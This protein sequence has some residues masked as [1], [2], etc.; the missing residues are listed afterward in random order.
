MDFNV[1]VSASGVRCGLPSM[2]IA[3]QHGSKA[4]LKAAG[5]PGKLTQA[6]GENLPILW[7]LFVPNS[8][9]NL[10]SIYKAHNRLNHV[11]CKCKCNWHLSHGI[12][13]KIN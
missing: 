5:W 13:S 2:M 3:S 8:L 7:T 9:K 10:R 1:L 6:C 4:K 11:N 12:F